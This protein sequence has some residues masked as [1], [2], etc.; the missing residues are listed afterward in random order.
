MTKVTLPNAKQLRRLCVVLLPTH[1]HAAAV[2]AVSC[3]ARCAA[4]QSMPI[5]YRVVLGIPSV[6][7]SRLLFC[8]SSRAVLCLSTSRCSVRYV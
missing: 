5:L 7:D 6:R 4:A 3:A 2:S 1:A 8:S